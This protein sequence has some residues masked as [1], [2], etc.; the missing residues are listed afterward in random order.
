MVVEVMHTQTL[1]VQLHQLQLGMIQ[2]Q[3][4]I[5]EVL[6]VVPHSIL[7]MLVVNQHKMIII[8]LLL[9]VYQNQQDIQVVYL[10]R[11]LFQLLFVEQL[12]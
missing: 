8:L 4:G 5:T 11:V 6:V 3:D 1:M 9:L 10:K 7:Q 2:I 12:I